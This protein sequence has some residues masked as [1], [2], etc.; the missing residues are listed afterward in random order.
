MRQDGRDLIQEWLD[1]HETLGHNRVFVNTTGD[2]L[3]VDFNNV[4]R[5]LGKYFVSFSKRRQSNF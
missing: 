3:K 5:L 2:L 1:D 4:D